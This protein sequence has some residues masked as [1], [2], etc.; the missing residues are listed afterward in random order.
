MT[1][2]FTPTKKTS[3]KDTIKNYLLKGY[4]IR[5]DFRDETPLEVMVR[6][7]VKYLPTMH[8]IGQDKDAVMDRVYCS[9]NLLKED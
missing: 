8:N 2:A 1:M 5:R 4:I 9:H 3:V 6:D 7:L